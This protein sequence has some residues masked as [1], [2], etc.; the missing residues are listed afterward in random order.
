LFLEFARTWKSSQSAADGYVR[1]EQRGP[2]TFRLPLRAAAEFAL[3]KD[4]RDHWATELLEEDTYFSQAD[5]E[6]AFTERG[7]RIVVSCERFNPWI[8][9]HRYA[10]KFRLS[11]VDGRALPFPP[12][13][14]L[15]VGEKVRP[16]AGV[17]LLERERKSI[18]RPSF[19]G[20]SGWRRQSDGR[21]F[22]LAE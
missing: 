20:L 21:V 10:G 7:L 18:E 3:R 11:D 8:V 4:Y 12:T 17:R 16:K 19:L 2:R 1:F 22:E 5:F 13:N 9:E 15:I 6:R 14:Y